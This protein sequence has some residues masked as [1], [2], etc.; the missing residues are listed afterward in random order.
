MAADPRLLDA[1]AARLVAATLRGEAPHRDAIDA[2]R[3]TSQAWAGRHF[4]D[5][6]S[7][8]SV[9]GLADSLSRL[10]RAEV[11]AGRPAAAQT[12]ARAIA[13]RRGAPPPAGEDAPLALDLSLLGAVQM[14][15]DPEIALPTLAEA[16]EVHGRL[17]RAEPVRW[18]GPLARGLLCL[19]AALAD[20]DRVDEARA[21]VSDLLGT[22]GPDGRVDVRRDGFLRPLGA[23]VDRIAPADDPAPDA[24]ALRDRFG[25]LG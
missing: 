21:V 24:A 16:R 10:G 6:G 17:A 18:R 12:L 23:L 7:P 11:A 9:V 25:A 3:L 19:G 14:M 1:A 15:L 4:A 13:H 2:L 22:I 8:A 20:L 5:G